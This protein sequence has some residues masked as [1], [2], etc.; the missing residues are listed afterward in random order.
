MAPNAFAAVLIAVISLGLVWHPPMSVTYR[1]KVAQGL[2]LAGAYVVVS[3]RMGVWMVP[4]LLGGMTLVGSSVGAW[5]AY[6]SC[7]EKDQPYD[8]TL[9]GG[10]LRLVDRDGGAPLAGQGN[11]NHA[12]SVG[13]LSTAACLGLLWLGDTWWAACLPLTLAATLLSC[14]GRMTGQWVS[15]GWVHLGWLGLTII[16]IAIG[17]LGA[18]LFLAATVIA[19]LL[20][21]HPWNP[22]PTW[23]DSNRFA[24]W[25]LALRQIWWPA[26]QAKNP[27][28]A[29]ARAEQEAAHLHAIQD[30]A[31]VEG[32]A[33]VHNQMTLALAQNAHTQQKWVVLGKQQRH[34]P[35]TPV[36]RAWA[37]RLWAQRVRV[38]LLGCGTGSWY[39]LTKWPV[40]LTTGT[41]TQRPD[42][43]QHLEGQVYLSAH[44][45][46]VEVLFEQGLVGLLAVL[47]FVAYGLHTT[48]TGGDVGLAVFLPLMVLLSI[49]FTNF[50]FTLFAEVEKANPAQPTQFVGSPALLVM[51]WTVLLLVEAVR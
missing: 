2:V 45:E 27:T 33:L 13:A 14:E 31:A 30:K 16:G 15:Q 40:L 3:P 4:W 10:W 46:Y 36:E 51:S 34:E 50:P 42:G 48:W 18:G 5:A 43:T 8:H 22:R 17:G 32:N 19:L 37:R 35:L 41:L 39:P 12:Q 47:G 26:L 23:Y 24:T 25:N 20:W 38:R 21:A 1:E 29:L 7:Q 9:F 6:S 44:N 11:F 49:A 28:E